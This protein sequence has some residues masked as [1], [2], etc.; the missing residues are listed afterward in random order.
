MSMKKAEKI[1]VVDNLIETI[2]G[3]KSV[4]IVDYQG[5][6][7]HDVETLRHE[8]RAVGGYL[9]VVKNT[10]LAR[11][12]KA[13][14]GEFGETVNRGL[15]GPTA[16]IIAEEDE[17]APLEKVGNMI[18]EKERPKLKFG[19]FNNEILDAAKLLVLSRLPGKNVLLRQALGAVA[20]PM[21]GLV[22]T[23]QGNL[24]K[25][26]YILNQKSKQTMTS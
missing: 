5:L 14:H 8:L 21:Y 23:L 7:T 1:F 10:L 16:V 24:Q 2:K 22:G 6:S 4:T 11:A 9:G 26:V 3:A 25:L 12:M 19:I 13:V 17:I 18:S 15:E 20:G